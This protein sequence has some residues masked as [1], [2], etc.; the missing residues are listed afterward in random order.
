M[1][2]VWE[3]PIAPATMREQFAGTEKARLRLGLQ[4]SLKVEGLE[5]L[6][7]L[8]NSTFSSLPESLKLQFSLRPIKVI[9]L[10]DKSDLGVRFDL[11]ERLNTGGV[12]LTNQEI[13]ACI[14][15]GPLNEFFERIAKRPA[16]H[17]VVLLTKRQDE[18]GTREECVLR[19]FAFFH[20][21]KS[22][23]HSVVVF[24][25]QYMKEASLSFDFNTNE[26]LFLNTFV[27]IFT[28]D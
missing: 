14:Y 10:S 16:F 22:F 18:D 23:D 27:Y 5:K 13:R 26:K 12:A 9:T 25:N 24:L 3:L 19:F 15:R 1:V 21:Y 28:Y 11:F 2:I 4:H 17:E 6:S 8:N 7:E 20:R